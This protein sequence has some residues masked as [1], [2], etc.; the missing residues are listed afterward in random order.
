MSRTK[1][2]VNILAIV[3]ITLACAP[4]LPQPVVFPTNGPG[5]IDTFVAAT[6]GVAATQTAV[7]AP[8]S[9]FTPTTTPTPSN[10]PTETP[11]PTNTII[12]RLAT[13]TPVKV[14]TSTKKVVP[15]STGSG[16][17]G[18]GG[19]GTTYACSVISVTPANKTK[20][21]P[22]DTF[23]AQWKVKNTGNV[24]WDHNSVDY[25]Y[26][27]GAALQTQALYDL[28][29]DVAVN[30]S[31]TLPAS[32]QAPASTGTYSTTWNLRSGADKFCTMTLTI[33]VQ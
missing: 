17:G 24:T 19:G 5:A 11:L 26:I 28:P 13:F 27:S 25:L 21:S 2:V 32:M 15:T 22:N 10:T 30:A 16:G 29:S 33:I 3:V 4:L 8:T 18:G 20:F 14:A 23:T 12:F 6:Y 1:R 9:T 7:F 31:I